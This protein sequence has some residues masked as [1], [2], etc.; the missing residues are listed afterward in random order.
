MSRVR[1]PQEIS[2]ETSRDGGGGEGMASSAQHYH[3]D[4]PT[5]SLGY[6][7]MGKEPRAVCSDE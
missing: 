3:R 4:G 5:S 2:G 7:S 1:D 6:V